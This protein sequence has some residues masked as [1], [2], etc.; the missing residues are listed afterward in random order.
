MSFIL[1]LEQV[2]WFLTSVMNQ[3]K[4]LVYGMRYRALNLSD[5]SFIKPLGNFLRELM[6]EA[7]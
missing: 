5:G 1:L 6:I 7:Y 3:V 2:F 4:Y